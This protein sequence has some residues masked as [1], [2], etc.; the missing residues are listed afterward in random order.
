MILVGFIVA[1]LWLTPLQL[2][3]AAV[4]S[5][6]PNLI[7]PGIGGIALPDWLAATAAIGLENQPHAGQQYDLAGLSGDAWRYARVVVYRLEQNLGPAAL[8]FGIVESS[9]AAL[10]ELARPLLEKSLAENGGKILEWSQDLAWRSWRA[11]DIRQIDN[12]RKSAVTDGGYRICVHAQREIVC[13][14]LFR[15]GQRSTILGKSC[16]PDVGA[17]EVGVIFCRK[18]RVWLVNVKITRRFILEIKQNSGCA[19]P[20][21]GRHSRYFV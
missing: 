16:H 5:D 8:L 4:A 7:L 21:Q 19:E 11:D 20:Q 1:G 14:G 6:P 2:A 12:D 13:V 10:G 3:N 17:A 18:L 9:P 15:T